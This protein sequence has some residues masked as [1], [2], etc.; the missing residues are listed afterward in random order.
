MKKKLLTIPIEIYR[1]EFVYQ[2]YLALLAAKED[3]Q[4]LLGQQNERHFRL[5]RNSIFYHKDHANWSTAWYKLAIKRKMK[6]VAFDIEGLIYQSEEIY[7]NNRVSK[8]VLNNID[9]VFLWG[10][11]QKKLVSK[12][13]DA[14]NQVI[15]GSPKFDLCNLLRNS[16]AEKTKGGQKRILINTRF[17]STNISSAEDYFDN[18]IKLGV[19]RSEQDIIEYKKFIESENAI[20]KEFDNLIRLISVNREFEVT[21]RPHPAEDCEFYSKRYCK[22]DNVIVDSETE[23]YEQILSHDIVVHDGCTTGIEANCMGKTVFGL[24]PNNLENAYSDFANNFSLNFSC[25][26][27]LYRHLCG[28]TFGDDRQEDIDR[29]ASNHIHNWRSSTVSATY[30]I[31]EVFNNLDVNYQNLLNVPRVYSFSYKHFLFTLVSKISLLMPLMK[32]G[33]VKRFIRGREKIESKFPNLDKGSVKKMIH[34]LNDLDE[35]TVKYD[36]L[37]IKYLSKKSILIYKNC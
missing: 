4:I 1:R 25:H 17:A 29:M 15:I 6:T 30:K 3:Y 31:I 7:L 27:D 20:F 37:V 26:L 22:F 28:A 32:V 36:D 13:V 8:W 18:L 14:S 5:A 33:R 2:L 34:Y 10:N 23:L 11:R 12:V 19:L 9:V 24:R 35:N 16:E 21:I